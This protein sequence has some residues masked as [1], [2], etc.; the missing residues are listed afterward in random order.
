MNIKVLVL[1]TI[2]VSF[3][4]YADEPRDGGASFESEGQS[5]RDVQA[6]DGGKR[7]LIEQR[8]A[9]VPGH[10]V[11]LAVLE[12]G[13][14]STEVVNQ[15][16]TSTVMS[17]N[18]QNQVTNIVNVGTDGLKTSEHVFYSDGSYHVS[19]YKYHSDGTP[20]AAPRVVFYTPEGDPQKK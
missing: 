20:S 3:P 16:G 9:T 4:A 2:L 12:T 15:D 7:A 1:L 18:D 11:G 17:W 14:H 10:P 5:V 13:P 6:A 8:N 19:H